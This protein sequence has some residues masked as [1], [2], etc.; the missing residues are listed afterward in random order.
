MEGR[1]APREVL[2]PKN[3]P[4]G[5]PITNFALPGYP[6]RRKN[7]GQIPF[8]LSVSAKKALIASHDRRSARSL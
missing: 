3:L 5:H 8:H 7:R 6:R 4:G 2:Y 1:R